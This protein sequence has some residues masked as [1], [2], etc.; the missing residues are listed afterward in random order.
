[1]GG[2]EMKIK[3]YH[4]G[5]EKIEK[6]RVD[7]GRP[8]LD[9]GRGFYITDMRQQAVDWAKRVGDR[10][11]AAPVLNTYIL[12]RDAVIENFKC[13]IFSEY[14]GEW[15]D[16][17]V[18]SRNG[19]KPWAKYDYI[20]GGVANDRVIDTISLYM[21]DLMTREKAIEKLSEHRPNNQMCLL[22]QG[23]IDQYLIFDGTE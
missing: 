22:N 9:F 6:P 3:V 13:K 17:I 8:Y 14:N 1:M 19:K 11:N 7:V 21:A 12:D 5:I 18:D 10:Q 20:E 2:K 15:L 23:I 16:F 4:G